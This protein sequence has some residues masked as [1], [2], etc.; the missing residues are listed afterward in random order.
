MDFPESDKQNN[1]SKSSLADDIEELSKYISAPNNSP[2]NND[3]QKQS[4]ENDDSSE[5]NESN[6]DEDKNDNDDVPN[7]I[8]ITSNDNDSDNNDDQVVEIITDSINTVTFEELII[9]NE[10]QKRKIEIQNNVIN[11]LRADN[12]LTCSLRTENE[13]LLKNIEEKN[14]IIRENNEQITQFKN[15]IANHALELTKQISESENKANDHVITL[16]NKITELEK[17]ILLINTVQTNNV[18]EEDNKVATENNNDKE[19][20]NN[21]DSE[22]ENVNGTGNLL[23]DVD[24]VNRMSD[25]LK[26][27]NEELDKKDKLYKQR[28]RKIVF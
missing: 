20:E 12:T 28:R 16:E 2:E 13:T 1:V 8:N 4:T 27:M 17:C 5:N 19:E 21:D 22:E 26:E 11:T 3:S 24:E 18:E 9:S 15:Q 7:I 6:K 25:K 10:N 14:S 23:S